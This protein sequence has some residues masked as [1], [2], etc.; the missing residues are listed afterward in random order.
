MEY[1]KG[2]SEKEIE[3][4]IAHSVKPEQVFNAKGIRKS[5]YCTIME[6]NGQIVAFNTTPCNTAGHKLR[7][8]S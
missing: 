7:T 5:V 8:R 4:L 3:F 1:P 2:L 6:R